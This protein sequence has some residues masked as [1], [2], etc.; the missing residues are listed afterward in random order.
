[1]SRSLSYIGKDPAILD[2]FVTAVAS[3]TLANGSKVVVNSD[4]TVSAVVEANGAL[5]PPQPGTS[6]IYSANSV[7]HTNCT[8]D[9]EHNRV[10]VVYYDRANSNYGTANVGEVSGTSISFGSPV[11]YNSADTEG[12]VITFDSDSDRVVIMIKDGGTS[13]YG[14]AVVGDVNPS[15]NSIAF[16]SLVTFESAN[17]YPLSMAFDSNSNKVVLLYTDQGNSNNLTAVVGDVNPSNNSI[18]FGTPVSVGVASFDGTISFDSTVNKIVVAYS[19]GSNYGS[20]KVGTITASNNSI[21]FGTEVTFNSAATYNP[22][23]VYDPDANKTVIFFRDGGDGQ[24]AKA[25]VATMNAGSNALGYGSIS[26][27]FT[28]FNTAIGGAVY[29]TNINKHVVIYNNQSSGTVQQVSVGTVDGT[30]IS[31]GTASATSADTSGLTTYLQSACFDSS[32]NKVVSVFRKTA[33]DP[34]STSTN[35]GRAVVISTSGLISNLTAENY[36]GISDSAY[37]DGQDAVIQVGGSVDDAQSS[38]TVGQSYFVQ[39]DGSLGT[40]ADDPSVFAG[41]AIAAT[42]LVVKG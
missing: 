41:T 30:S 31:F 37:T 25:V 9:S 24:K 20:T 21:A 12:N 6:V 38:L 42:K 17:T 3:G 18:A 15:N 13:N 5:N 19:G 1:M 29:D 28:S 23:C 40:T 22:R 2:N 14:R 11:V 10:V 27:A 8:F 35:K 34:N 26:S 4:G 39:T 36:I 7:V 33:S 32:T 16:G